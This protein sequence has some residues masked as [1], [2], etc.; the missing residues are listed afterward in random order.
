M[1]E[2]GDLRMGM[3]GSDRAPHPYPHPSVFPPPAERTTWICIDTPKPQHTH[4]KPWVGQGFEE[5]SK[6]DA[7]KD[8]NG[9]CVATWTHRDALE[10]FL[11]PS[12]L[13]GLKR[14]L[15]IL[16]AANYG[17][18]VGVLKV[19]REEIAKYEPPVCPS[20]KREMP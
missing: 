11:R 5:C 10:T 18:S 3:H 6:E 19:V 13:L 4:E 7:P 14:A 9:F 2:N 20:C 12:P 1:N 16:E 17:V 15:E 8:A